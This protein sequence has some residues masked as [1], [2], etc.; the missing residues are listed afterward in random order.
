MGWEN[1]QPQSSPPMHEDLMKC[2]LALALCLMA[3]FFA[4]AL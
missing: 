3:I 2:E 1:F 4:E